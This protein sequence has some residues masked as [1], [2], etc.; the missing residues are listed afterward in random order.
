M[1]RREFLG[2]LAAATVYP[3][4]AGCREM[5]VRVLCAHTPDNTFMTGSDWLWLRTTTDQ[6]GHVKRYRSADGETWERL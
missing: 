2:A 3:A 1:R 4:F 5:D 6:C